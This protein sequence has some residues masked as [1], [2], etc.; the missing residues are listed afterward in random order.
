[1]KKNTYRSIL[2]AL[3]AFLILWFT[4]LGRGLSPE[5]P[6]LELFWSYQEW[7]SGKWDIGFQILGNIAMFAPLGFMLSGTCR[8][9]WSAVAIALLLSCV[10]E[11]SQ[12]LSM[13]GLFEFDDIF[14][15]TL[16][17][18]IGSGLHAVIGE[19]KSGTAFSL[20]A[21][22]GF[23]CICFYYVRPVDSSARACCFQV[24][25]DLSGF[26]LFFDHDTPEEYTIVLKST[27]SGKKIAMDPETA[28]ERQDV[29]DYFSCEHDYSKSGFQ[30]N[31]APDMGEYEFLV[32]YK[33]FVTI[34][35]GV[36]L[37]DGRVCYTKQSTFIPPD[38]KSDFIADGYLRVYRPDY[39]CWVY[40]YGG[41]LY[42]VVD[43]DF[44]FV[45]DGLT[46]I[47]Y[48]LW[49]TQIDKLP[50]HRLEN[51]WY[52]DNIGAFFEDYELEGDFGDYRVMK[53]EIPTEYAVTAIE[54][55]YYA[56]HRWVWREFFRPIYEF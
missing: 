53:R 39:H 16:G 29:N 2:P 28:I 20:A 10:I 47:Q 5:P 11:T 46:Y 35:T 37:N 15:N 3:Y 32:K 25:E 52:W 56:N 23:T 27:E 41:A 14:N 44:N 8:K 31:T 34:H 6:K 18:L 43:K 40:Q 7:F 38:M 55:G 45:D 22:L 12:L 9:R 54:T 30:I 33:P 26:F 36:Y 48:H 17:S 50:K 42:W 51:K 24:D 4:V 49:T 19:R 1:M 13:R 21:V